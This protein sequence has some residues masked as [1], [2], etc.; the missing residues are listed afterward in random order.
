MAKPISG[1]QSVVSQLRKERTNLV[2]QLR[3]VDAALY[4][5]GK[6]NGGRI[7]TQPRHRKMSVAARARIAATQRARWAKVKG[8]RKVVSIAPKRRRI[9]PAGL[10]RIRAATTSTWAKRRAAQK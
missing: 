2:N 8:Q 7:Y 5:L 4:V 3:H 10:A 1:L 6:L 9:T